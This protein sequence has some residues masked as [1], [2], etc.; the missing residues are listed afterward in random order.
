MTRHIIDVIRDGIVD[1]FIPYSK[2]EWLF[3]LEEWKL[4]FKDGDGEYVDRMID[5]LK[6][7]DWNVFK[8]GMVKYME[9]QGYKNDPYYSKLC[10]LSTE[11]IAG[12]FKFRLLYWGL[13]GDDF[14]HKTYE[15][16]HGD[17]VFDLYDDGKAYLCMMDRYET[18][19]DD[20]YDD[21]GKVYFWVENQDGSIVLEKDMVK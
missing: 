4:H 14:L 10:G 6:Y 11:Y 18:L 19:M 21:P 1:R 2:E 17:D 16:R 13:C 3:I 12:C 5:A 8:M 9:D 7:E 20:D 15:D